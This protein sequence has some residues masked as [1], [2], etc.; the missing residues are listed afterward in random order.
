MAMPV[1]S[2]VQKA[3]EPK[4]SEPKPIVLSDSERTMMV[5][6]VNTQ[7][8]EKVGTEMCAEKREFLEVK[9][10]QNENGEPYVHCRVFEIA[11]S[12]EKQ[13]D[14][15]VSPPKDANGRF[16]L[17]KGIK[18]CQRMTD[19]AVN[20]VDSRIFNQYNEESMSKDDKIRRLYLSQV[21]KAAL[22]KMEGAQLTQLYEKV[23][24]ETFEPAS[25]SID[26]IART[27]IDH[28]QKPVGASA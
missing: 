16:I 8:R 6:R 25:I 17:E 12:A 11:L 26:E 28:T 10:V 7:L 5:S 19:T 4:L 24:K 13:S 15:T 3:N 2:A 21:F 23:R 14:G 1:A 22:G 20:D 9:L 18:E 27:L